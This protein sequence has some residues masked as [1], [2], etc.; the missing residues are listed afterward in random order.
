MNK[1][2]E[3]LK[4]INLLETEMLNIDEISPNDY[5][6]NQMDSE[7]IY[8]LEREIKKHGFFQEILVRPEK[9][10]KGVKYTIIDG[11]HRWKAMKNLG[12]KTIPAK[13]YDCSDEEA[14]ALTIN[15][16]EIK[17]KG[18]TL[19]LAGLINQ[20]GKEKNLDELS[21]VLAFS[22]DR[23]VAHQN[24]VNFDWDSYDEEE[25][26]K[27]DKI[28][29]KKDNKLDKLNDGFGFKLREDEHELLEKA[30]NAFGG[31]RENALIGIC[32]YYLNNI[33]KDDGRKS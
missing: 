5:N 12:S 2:K 32:N 20:V 13:I 33:K 22:K 8:F 14:M 24:L 16:N 19:K 6:Y 3:T 28:L 21:D 7:T 10:G 30:L 11:E 26:K 29:E 4:K 1:I 31:S 25:K 27:R 17:G 15:M 18:D 9:N 23:I